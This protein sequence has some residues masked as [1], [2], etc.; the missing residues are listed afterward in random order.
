MK[1]FSATS[2]SLV[3]FVGWVKPQVKP[4]IS[5]MPEFHVGF[6]SSTQPTGSFYRNVK[7]ITENTKTK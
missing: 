1:G 2:N 7:N 6:R 4:N 5:C 3:G